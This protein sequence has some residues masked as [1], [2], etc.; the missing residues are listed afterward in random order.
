MTIIEINYMSVIIGLLILNLF[1]IFVIF[2]L[3]LKLLAQKDVA[4]DDPTGEIKQ[5]IANN[6]EKAT[7][8]VKIIV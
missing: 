4:P 8:S 2:V 6:I 3:A 1:G 7:S 5:R